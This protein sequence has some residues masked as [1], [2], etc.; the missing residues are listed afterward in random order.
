MDSY[1]LCTA[2]GPEEGNTVMRAHWDAWVTEDH[3]KGLADREVEI[4]RL[5]IGDWTL[6]PYG[7]YVGC[8]DGAKDKIQWLLDTCEKYNIKV[9]L[10]VHAVKGSQNGYDNSGVANYTEWLDE[11]HFEHWAHAYGEWMG[12]WGDNEYKYINLDNIDWAVDTIDGLLDTWGHHPAVY[13]IEPV[14]EPWWSSDLALLRGYYRRVHARM[15][16]AAPHLKFVFHDAFHGDPT[17]WNQMF[18]DDEDYSNVIMSHHFYTAW[19][20]N[21]D[22]IQGYCDGYQ[23]EFEHQDLIK[24]PTWVTEWSLATDVCAMWL[25]GFNDNNSPIVQECQM[26]DCPYSYISDAEIGVDFDRTAEKLGPFGSNELSTVHK[27]KC[28][29]DSAFYSDD[30]VNTLGKCSTSIMDQYVAGQFLWTF[31]NEL[32]PRWSYAEAYDAGW[33]K[34]GGPRESTEFLQ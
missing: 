17:T 14:N 27:G 7:P 21:Q 12:P 33:I 32:E 8:M 25:G 2:L 31:R 19:W 4:V 11:N 30:E 13:A 23:R 9:L 34:R 26:V 1:T 6:K 28:P 10:D 5:P 15:Q 24:Y 16:K 20:G 3:I 18:A 22:S 29:I